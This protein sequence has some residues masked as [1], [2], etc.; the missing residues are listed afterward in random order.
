MR[1]KLSISKEGVFYYTREDLKVMDEARASPTLQ[2]LRAELLTPV[3]NA[4]KEVAELPSVAATAR[5]QA[6]GETKK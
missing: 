3:A 1:A 6:T 4:S 2:K 5:A